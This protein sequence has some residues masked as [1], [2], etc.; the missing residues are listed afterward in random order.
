[1]DVEGRL[2]TCGGSQAKSTVRGAPE[3]RGSRSRP[4]Y[5]T[6]S[7][8]TRPE[9]FTY[10]QGTGS[11]SF[12]R[13]VVFWAR[14][15]LPRRRRTALSGGEGKRTLFITAVSAVWAVELGVEG[16]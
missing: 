8:R 4:A 14:S 7:G 15:G 13:R 9:R 2:I 6:A 12:I 5:L 16:R 10:A 1:M 3:G 11:K